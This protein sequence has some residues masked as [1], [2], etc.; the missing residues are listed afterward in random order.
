MMYACMNT[1]IS[2]LV[3]TSSYA[4]MKTTSHKHTRVLHCHSHNKWGLRNGFQRVFSTSLLLE[5]RWKTWNWPSII[6][7]MAVWCMHVW[8]CLVGTNSSESMKSTS[9][10]VCIYVC[11]YI[12][13]YVYMYVC[14]SVCMY[15]CM[16]SPCRYQF[17]CVYEEHLLS[18][19]GIIMRM[20]LICMRVCIYVCMYIC[21]IYACMGVCKCVHEYLLSWVGIIMRMILACMRVYMYV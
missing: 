19:V 16:N 15:I 1:C 13:M 21:M 7:R 20:I 2:C 5:N 9:F 17:V 12:C 10:R 18:L 14:I 3:G 11:M 4:S 8:T 6:M